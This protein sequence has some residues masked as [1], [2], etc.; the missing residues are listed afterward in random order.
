MTKCCMT[1][2]TFKCKKCNSTQLTYF[3]GV[4]STVITCSK[5]DCLTVLLT[6]HYS[7]PKYGQE[8]KKAV[9]RTIIDYMRG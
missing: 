8:L 4:S 7:H 6:Y 1:G 5:N 2:K 3:Y 9:K